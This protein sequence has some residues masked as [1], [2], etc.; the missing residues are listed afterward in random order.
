MRKPTLECRSHVLH[1]LQEAASKILIN[2]V[3]TDVVI[4]CLG[5]FSKFQSICPT[6]QIWI[7]FGKGRH[8]RYYHLNL[9]YNNL[10]PDISKSVPF[11]HAFT[12]RDT[13]SQF[14]GRGKKALWKTWKAFPAV[15]PAF[16]VESHFTPFNVDS[17]AFALIEHFVCVMY[18]R[19]TNQTRVND[20]RQ[21]LF[22]SAK[23]VRMMQHL[24][25]TQDALCLHANRCLYQASIW[26][27]SLKSYL[28][29]PSPEQFGWSKVDDI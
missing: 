19:T 20:L 28:N 27:S 7:E 26:L 8:V 14:G 2:T 3:D 15:T 1:G 12:G 5:L 10:G 6:L 18:D 9:V 29:V 13:T 21:D 4:I 11:F 23:N 25:T 17:N 16:S 22:A 24:R